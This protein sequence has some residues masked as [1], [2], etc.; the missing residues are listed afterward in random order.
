MLLDITDQEQEFLLELLETKLK[1]MLHE[2]HHT[3]SREYK[4]LLRQDYDLAEKLRTKVENARRTSS[5]VR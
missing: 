1:A 5:A 4:E 3:D 2:I